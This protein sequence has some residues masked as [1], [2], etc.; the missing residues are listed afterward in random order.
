LSKKNKNKRKTVLWDKL[1]GKSFL[2]PIKDEPFDKI[3]DLVKEKSGVSPSDM[4]ICRALKK[5]NLKRNGSENKAV[6]DSPKFKL[7]KTIQRKIFEHL[8]SGPIPVHQLSDTFGISREDVYRVFE[9]IQQ[10]TKCRFQFSGNNSDNPIV[11]LVH[12]YDSEYQNTPEVDLYRSWV[13]VGF[14]YGTLIGSKWQQMDVL[15]TIYYTLG[16]EEHAHHGRKSGLNFMVHLGG[17]VFG[18]ITPAKREETFLD[19]A[20]VRERKQIESKLDKY[21]R[22]SQIKNLYGDDDLTKKDIEFLNDEKNLISSALPT[23]PWEAERDYFVKCWPDFKNPPSPLDP[24]KLRRFKTHFIAGGEERTFVKDG[25]NIIKSI[26]DKRDHDLKISGNKFAF[27]PVKN[28]TLMVT[29]SLKGTYRGSYT[30][31]ARAQNTADAIMADAELLVRQYGLKSV[32][33]L[34]VVAGDGSAVDF[35]QYAG[36]RLISLPVLNT[37][38]KDNTAEG[39]PNFG[40]VWLHIPFDPDTD[41]VILEDVEYHFE[42]LTEYI[43][44]PGY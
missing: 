15:Y 23:L 9:M 4:A 32:P 24:K 43:R 2:E 14:L 33:E 36:I 31:G 40:F 1:G 21:E 18:K 20:S 34:I 39:A 38:Y 5:Y 10:E 8:L 30:K 6:V 44:I 19:F 26:C 29:N 37:Y 25:I 35:G 42:D 12:E 28:I 41:K 17:A 11:R 3:R 13:N 7:G 27:F 16:Q 22:L